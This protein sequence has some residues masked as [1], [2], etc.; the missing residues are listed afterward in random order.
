MSNPNAIAESGCFVTTQWTQVINVIQQGNDDAAWRALVEFC[1]RYRPAI[2]NF[3]CRRGCSPGDAED[4]AQ[5]FFTSRII[6]KWDQRDTFLHAAKRGPQ[7]RFRSFLCHVL[8][9]FLHDHWKTRT[10]QKA[11][12][13]ACH[14]PLED[15]EASTEGADG[16]SFKNFG[17]EFDRAFARELLLK[18][19]GRSKHS[20]HLVAHL[21]QEISQEEAAQ[22]LGLSVGAFKQ[23]YHRFRQRLA[24]DLHEEVANLAGP[25]EEEIRAELKYLMSLFAEQIA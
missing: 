20:R 17:R 7:M 11:G 21:R 19:A 9:C 18:A 2:C 23:A 22:Q 24:L 3:F 15:L 6:E 14:I 25:D 13:G 4:L 8:W 10:T 1:E 5:A 12:G 16:E